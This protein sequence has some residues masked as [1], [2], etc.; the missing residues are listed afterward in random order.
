[1]LYILIVKRFELYIDFALYK[2]NIL[3]LLLTFGT[4]SCQCRCR[5]YKPSDNRTFGLE[6]SHHF[7][8]ST[9]SA[10]P[11][12]LTNEVECCSPP[13][14]TS[15]R[16]T[17]AHVAETQMN[18]IYISEIIAATLEWTGSHDILPA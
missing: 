9:K 13:R 11:I 14:D 7:S 6:S 17:H 16:Y 18:Y 3:L 12:W 8:S 5:T 1:M 10:D 4:E 15:V 2:I